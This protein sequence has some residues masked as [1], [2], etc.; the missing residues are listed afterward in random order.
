MYLP[1]VAGILVIFPFSLINNLDDH[2][3]CCEISFWRARKAGKSKGRWFFAARA[4]VHLSEG[5]DLGSHTHAQVYSGDCHTLSHTFLP[6]C[7]PGGFVRQ[8]R[9]ATEAPPG[10]SLK[11]RG[12][13]QGSAKALAGI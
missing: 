3:V 12:E 8:E 7:H 4:Q 13:G 11:R 9:G 5:R 2:Q 10:T 6:M 1:H